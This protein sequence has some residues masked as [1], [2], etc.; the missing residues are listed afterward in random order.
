MVLQG[1]GAGQPQRKSS[2]D[3]T[4]GQSPPPDDFRLWAVAPPMTAAERPAHEVPYQHFAMVA[5]DEHG[6]THFHCSPSLERVCQR[7]FV[8]E[9]REILAQYTGA[10]LN[11][12]R[13]LELLSPHSRKRRRGLSHQVADHFKYY[14]QRR[15]DS[16]YE[17]PDFIPIQIGDD[18]KI[19]LYY[20]QAF[21][22]LQ[23]LN[24]RTLAKAY[25]KMIEPRKQVRHPYNG[26]RVGPGE[27]PDP[28]KTK[29]SWWPAGVI[30]KEPDH[31]KKAERVELLIHIFRRMPKSRGITAEKLQEAAHE[32]RRTLSSQ[33][34]RDVLD[35]VYKVKRMEESYMRGEIDADTVIYVMNLE[36]S[37]KKAEREDSVNDSREDAKEPAVSC[38]STTSS[39]SV[40]PAMTNQQA[41]IT[42]PQPPDLSGLSYDTKPSTQPGYEYLS[43]ATF[44]SVP[45][46]DGQQ[47]GSHVLGH[48]TPYQHVVCG[49]V[50]YGAVTN[51]GAPMMAQALVPPQ[52]AVVTIEPSPM[53]M[54]QSHGL[55]LSD[56]GVRTQT[57]SPFDFMLPHLGGPTF[58]T[59]SLSHPHLP[60]TTDSGESATPDYK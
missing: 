13:H 19:E 28:E 2:K 11:T 1:I 18:K 47:Q 3:G 12:Q 55:L 58:R 6:R 38:A 41:H 48:W 42:F 23:Q 26:G 54:Y 17:K 32:A 5:I 44:E 49:H 45:V 51:S 40:E 4:P 46:E 50:D 52:P 15:E 29:P 39:S 59:G 43:Q 24:C 30:H 7:L 10:K 35:E 9:F 31:L 56:H 8:P 53:S 16:S 36:S 33:F 34:Q 25:I 60:H 37:S 57:Q 20:R 21:I 14:G 22:T 27:T